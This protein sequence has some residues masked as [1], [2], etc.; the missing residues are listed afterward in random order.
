MKLVGRIVSYTFLILVAL[1]S[2]VFA[3]VELR[4]LFAGDF[5]LMNNAAMSFFAYLFRGLF[6]VSLCSYSVYL[7]I[8]FMKKKD[9]EF[10]NYLIA[11]SLLIASLFTVFFYVQSIY[12]IIILLALVPAL[13]VLLRRFLIERK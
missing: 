1:V 2:L 9:L 10:F 13:V 5:L 3:F 12:L 8:F 7:F 11:I 6:F 4:S